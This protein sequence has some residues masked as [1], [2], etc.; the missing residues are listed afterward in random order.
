[1]SMTEDEA[2][3][4]EWMEE[5]YAEHSKQAIE[6]FTA[7]RLQS[8]Y[9]NNPLLVKPPL[10]ALV[11][12]RLLL[13]AHPAAALV[14]A[15]IAT[16]V[17]LKEVLLKPVVYGLVHSESAATLI[18]ELALGH[19]GMDRFRDLLYQI[20]SE[21]GG[22][23]LG[24]FVRPGCSKKLWEEVRDVQKRRNAILHRAELRSYEDV[25]QSIEVASCILETLFPAVATQ[26]G[27]HIHDGF[28]LCNQWRC[29]YGLEQWPASG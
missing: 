4:E 22:L 26:L 1:M 19:T 28:R 7:E 18:T 21:H 14:F 6:E 5:L 10:D 17:G 3:A 24:S 25:R 9:L 29:R 23:D 20:L 2:R 8:F 16:E 11:E 15:A 13:G 12:S 27:L